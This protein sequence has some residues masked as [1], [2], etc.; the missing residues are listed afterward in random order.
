MISHLVGGIAAFV[1]TNHVIGYSIAGPPQFT[2]GPRKKLSGHLFPDG[3]RKLA[4]GDETAGEKKTGLFRTSKSQNTIF[5][6]VCT[7]LPQN[8]LF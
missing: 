8:K 1:H 7:S 5:T 3:F 2:S 4:A 6:T